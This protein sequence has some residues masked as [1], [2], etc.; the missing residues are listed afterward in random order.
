M[1]GNCINKDD[2]NK[3]ILT[4]ASLNKPDSFSHTTDPLFTFH[5]YLV[6]PSYEIRK[7]IMTEL[8][9]QIAK[10]GITRQGCIMIEQIYQNTQKLHS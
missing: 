5:E 6:G 7:I 10:T 1:P 2:I 8:T 3:E 9:K 4:L